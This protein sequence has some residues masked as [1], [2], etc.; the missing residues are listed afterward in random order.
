MAGNYDAKSIK[1]LEGLE[2]V[3]RRPRN[4]HRFYWQDWFASFNL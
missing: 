1:V 2:G 3:R 4:V